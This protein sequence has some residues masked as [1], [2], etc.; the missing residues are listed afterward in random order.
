MAL[1]ALLCAFSW[2]SGI[3]Q[4][5]FG[6]AAFLG[7]SPAFW[8]RLRVYS[9][10]TMQLPLSWFL[11][12]RFAFLFGAAYIIVSHR[13]NN[14]LIVACVLCR[15]AAP[16]TRL[17]HFGRHDAGVEDASQMG[18]LTFIPFAMVGWLMLLLIISC[19]AAQRRADAGPPECTWWFCRR[20]RGIPAVRF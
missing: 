15:H 10:W 17:C 9:R 7:Y 6:A 1:L 14:S 16:C 5:S 2:Y 11:L 3:R 19:S 8:P 13:R 4:A 18:R 20:V 12:S